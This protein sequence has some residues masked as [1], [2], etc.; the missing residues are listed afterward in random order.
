LSQQPNGMYYLQI[1]NG[2]KI[3]MNER[4]ILNK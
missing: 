3:L 2:E 1:R 4:I